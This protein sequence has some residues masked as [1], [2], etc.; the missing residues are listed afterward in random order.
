MKS[1]PTSMNSVACQICCKGH[2]QSFREVEHIPYRRCDACGSIIADESA[3]KASAPRKYDASYWAF[4]VASAKER[5]FGPAIPRVAEVFA[6]CRI[7]IRRFLDISSGGGSLLDSLSLLLPEIQ[8]VF[9]GNEPFPPPENFRSRHPNYKVGWISDLTCHFD[10]GVCIEVIEHLFPDTL[11][12]MIA[13]L[14][15]KSN[16]RA[17]YYFNSAQ[18]SYVIER[19]PSYLDP[20]IRGHVVSYSVAGIA[21]LF[22]EFGFV[23]HPLPGRDWGFLAEYKGERVDGGDALMNRLWNPVKENIDLLEQ[24]K[25]GRMF[26][27]IGI[28]SSRCYLEAARADAFAARLMRRDD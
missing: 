28:E 26:R 10:A 11:R 18:P 5:S 4:E 23:V 22:S 27:S 17:L 2:M 6:M 19:E 9:H 12:G 8:G 21:A 1:G 3:Y 16:K 7:P 25:Y 20:F 24:C 14:A 15:L 13:Q